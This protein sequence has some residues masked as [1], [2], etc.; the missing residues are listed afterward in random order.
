MKVMAGT[1]GIPE[2]TPPGRRQNF[3]GKPACARQADALPHMKAMAG[4]LGI[5]EF[6]PPNRR[7]NFH[8]KDKK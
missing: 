6:T 2:F 5:P 4:A 7:Q 1:L 8:S 3:H